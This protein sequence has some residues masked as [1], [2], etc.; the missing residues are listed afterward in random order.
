MRNMKKG[1]LLLALAGTTLFGGCLGGM[2][3]RQLAWTAAISVGTQFLTDNNGVFD[4][5]DD[6]ST[7]A[8]ATP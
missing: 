7:E 1:A 6:G 4:L 5:F 8:A 3:W 2:G